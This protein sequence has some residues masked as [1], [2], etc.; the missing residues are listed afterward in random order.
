MDRFSARYEP[1]PMSGCWIW[2]GTMNKHIGYGTMYLSDYKTEY[3]HRVS[4][5]LFKGELVPGLTIDHLCRTRICVNPAHLEQV[6]RGENVLRGN[7][8]SAINSRKTH[9]KMGHE[10][11]TENLSPY[12]TDSR[13]CKICAVEWHRKANRKYAHKR[14]EKR[15]IARAAAAND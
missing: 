3:A 8:L 7:S 9:C 10:F 2:T 13:V 15:R 14:R 1:E 5:G 6:T 12:F 11:S 4:Y